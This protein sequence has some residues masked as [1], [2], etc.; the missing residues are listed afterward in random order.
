MPLAAE[1]DWALRGKGKPVGGFKLEELRDALPEWCEQ[2]RQSPLRE[3]KGKKIL[4]FATLHYWIGHATLSALALRGMGHEV[5]LATL[6][7]ANWQKALNKF[8]AR[9]R[10]L[11]IAEVLNPASDLINHVSFAQNDGPLSL[12]RTISEAVEHVSVM[13]VQY[14]LQVEDVDKESELYQLRLARN[15]AAAAA[16][17]AWIKAEEPDVVILPNGLILEFGAVFHAAKEADVPVVSYE[18]GEQ[19]E[20]IWMAQNSSVMLQDTDAMWAARGGMSF[21]DG[22]RKKVTELFSSRQQADL[23]QNFYRRWQ[24]VPS[25]GAQ[26][27][28]EKLS[29]DERP[30]VL[31]AANVIGDS[32]TLG[33]A[34]FSGDMSS[35]LRR[36]V[37]HFAARE[38]VQFVLRVHPGERN[39]EGPSV[40]ELIE[41]ALPE[42]PAHMRIVK[43]DDPINT[44]DLI[45]AADLGL[46][47]TTTVGMEMAMSG[48][49]VIVVGQ[50]HYRGKGF[51]QDPQSWADYFELLENTLANLEESRPNE[52][53]VNQAWHYAYRFF[54]DYPQIFPWHLLHF[55]EDVKNYSLENLFSDEGQ[56]QFRRSFD[57]LSGETFDWQSKGS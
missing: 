57:Y 38:D 18:F 24:E 28:R 1:V 33:R 27:L 56:E 50:T 40:A 48:L 19:R 51:T 6:P 12:A 21:D 15:L 34:T 20:R 31:L 13:D 2:S 22:Q 10:E 14:S 54:F 55:W 23:F 47:Y 37:E 7:Y 16:A 35:W 32:L 39:L 45:A 3:A 53:E 46:V 42:L 5:T 30:M 26:Q 36:T 44:Y 9:K 25:E 49:P 8:D 11:Y 41:Q 4:V 17:Q 43:A 29:L 52:D